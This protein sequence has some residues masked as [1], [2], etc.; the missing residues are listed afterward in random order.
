MVLILG[1]V[2]KVGETSGV[3]REV[4]VSVMASLATEPLVYD[5]IYEITTNLEEKLLPWLFEVGLLGFFAIDCQCFSKGKLSLW[6]DTSSGDGFVWK[7]SK[8]DG[9]YTVSV[10]HES[11]FEKCKLCLQYIQELGCTELIRIH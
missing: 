8:K 2:E 3:L 7:C 10:R 9:H 1:I 4:L 11:W 6:K 5:N